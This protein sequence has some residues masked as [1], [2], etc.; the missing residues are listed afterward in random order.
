MPW[1]RT[2]GAAGGRFTP[3]SITHILIKRADPKSNAN[4]N[5]GL[6][7]LVQGHNAK[8]YQV[9]NHKAKATN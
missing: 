1:R 4:E 8:A 7:H 5:R 3:A 6:E 9:D 2:Q